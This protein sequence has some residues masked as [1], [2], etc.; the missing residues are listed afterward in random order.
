MFNWSF[1]PMDSTNLNVF[2][3]FHV[4]LHPRLFCFVINTA[5]TCKYMLRT[6]HVL[7]AQWT[8][9]YGYFFDYAFQ[10]LFL[11]NLQSPSKEWVCFLEPHNFTCIHNMQ[12][13]ALCILLPNDNINHI[14]ICRQLCTKSGSKKRTFP[15]QKLD[16]WL[17]KENAK[18]VGQAGNYVVHL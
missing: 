7:S 8:I 13:G 4:L 1:L 11:L 9:M 6:K 3:R 14:F 18:N 16:Q 2:F 12:L 15:G 17:Y 5:D 10:T